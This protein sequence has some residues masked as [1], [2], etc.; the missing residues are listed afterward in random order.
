M[1]TLTPPRL[2][3]W[4]VEGHPT[5]AWGSAPS[6]AHGAHRPLRATWA[7][8]GLPS[9]ARRPPGLGRLQGP[10]WPLHLCLQSPM[11]SPGWPRAP[12]PAPP[13]QRGLMGATPQERQASPGRCSWSLTRFDTF[14]ATV[15]GWA[16]AL[17][18]PL[19]A[20]SHTRSGPEEEGWEPAFPPPSRPVTPPP[21]HPSLL[22]PVRSPA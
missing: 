20:A 15:P 2:G 6:L 9:W 8:L 21:D 19:P 4:V 3:T 12:I 5:P 11:P 1:N 22:C 18:K 13:A 16:S 17:P 10:R 7:R 14:D